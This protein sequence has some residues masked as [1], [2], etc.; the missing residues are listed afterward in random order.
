MMI[1]IGFGRQVPRILVVVG[2]LAAVVCALDFLP[3]GLHWKDLVVIAVIGL[4]FA[5]LLLR[6]RDLAPALVLWIPVLPRGYLFARDMSSWSFVAL[7]FALLFLGALVS[8]FLKRKLLPPVSSSV[9]SVGEDTGVSGP[10]T[11]SL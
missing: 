11:E 6:T 4:L 7:S 10:D 1:A 5:L 8:L 2:G 3:K 9:P